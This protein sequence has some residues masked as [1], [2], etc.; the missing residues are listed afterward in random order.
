MASDPF[1]LEGRTVAITGAAGFLGRALSRA[2]LERG[3]R[4][5]ALGRSERLDVECATWSREF[6]ADR[7][8]A[9]RADMRDDI[10]L[11][12]VLRTLA[13]DEA[14]DVLVNNA[15]ALDH[16]SGFN[17]PEGALENADKDVWMRNLV[18]GV[19]WPAI[20]TRVVGE[21][22]VTRGRG[23]II[24]IA[25]MY[26]LVAPSPRLYEGTSF[27]NPAPYS[28]AKAAM[29]AL[30]RYTA[31][32][33]GMHGVRANAIAPGPFS[34]TD[35]AGE[36]SVGE[37][38]PFLARLRA[39]TSLGRTGRPQELAG[40]LVFLA[41]DASSYVTGHCLVVDGGWTIV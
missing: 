17:V 29:L 21:G 10:A 15:H 36:N 40:P 6:G 37:G 3:A 28:A 2:V 19:W 22:M 23:S 7:L 9:V 20:T 24:N 11:E 5:V 41:S 32:F 33:W 13:A 8:R 25:S 30:T 1:S 16:A 39:R 38:D 35:E 18:S 26:G 12:R 27:I 4:L 14:I 34:N 31:S